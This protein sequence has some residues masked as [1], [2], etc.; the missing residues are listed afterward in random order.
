MGWRGGGG[1]TVT[2]VDERRKQTAGRVADAGRTSL[3][4]NTP[5]TN[6][7]GCLK[8][9][10]FVNSCASV[11]LS[12]PF[13]LSGILFLTSFICLFE[14]LPKYVPVYFSKYIIFP[15]PKIVNSL[16]VRVL[17]C[18]RTTYSQT[19]ASVGAAKQKMTIDDA[20]EPHTNDRRK[21][22]SNP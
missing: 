21:H 18:L 1:R 8:E 15:Y 11:F 12:L 16:P 22:S 7:C 5:T 14:C 10:C 4:Y 17:N 19:G 20:H 9:R 3:C 13:D 6:C 2:A